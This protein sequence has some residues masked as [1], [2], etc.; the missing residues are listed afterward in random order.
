MFIPFVPFSLLL[1]LLLGSTHL[2]S[3]ASLNA[4][5]P[6]A[7]A[8]LFPLPYT[9]ISFLFSFPTL[10]S[11]P[12]L[13]LRM[14]FVDTERVHYLL[15][16]SWDAPRCPPSCLGRPV[17]ALWGNCG[18]TL[19]EGLSNN[20]VTSTVPFKQT[21]GEKLGELTY[22]HSKG[23]LQGESWANPVLSMP[24]ACLKPTTPKSANVCA[25]VCLCFVTSTL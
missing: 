4:Y 8:H 22:S 18:E 2:S 6:E 12:P 24:L 7:Y 13:S 10:F 5:I 20:L 25:C 11:S 1:L 19:L 15:S 9:Q 17:M 16:G 21:L 3:P 14:A 23:H